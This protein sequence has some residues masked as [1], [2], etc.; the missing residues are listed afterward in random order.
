MWMS[1]GGHV[2]VKCPLQN[3][4]INGPPPYNSPMTLLLKSMLCHLSQKLK[5]FSN[6]GAAGSSTNAAQTSKEC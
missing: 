2:V 4:R 6:G 3:H 1:A 5:T